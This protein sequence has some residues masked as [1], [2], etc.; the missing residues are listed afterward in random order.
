MSNFNANNQYIS[1]YMFL[2][3]VFDKANRLKWIKKG[4]NFLKCPK[5]IHNLFACARH[6]VRP[7]LL[8]RTVLGKAGAS[9]TSQVLGRGRRHTSP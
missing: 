8:A 7:P 2:L 4:K 9:A 6:H 5:T 1:N 3:E